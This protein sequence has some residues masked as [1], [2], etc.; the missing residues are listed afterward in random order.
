MHSIL[1][2]LM[3]GAALYAERAAATQFDCAQIESRWRSATAGTSFDEWTSI[4]YDAHYESNCGNRIVG[5]IGRDIIERELPAIRSAYRASVDEGSLRALR[6]RLDA[7]LEY[8]SH[9]EISFLLGETARK[10]RDAT[11]ALTAYRE[12]LGLVDNEELTPTPPHRDDIALLRDRLDETAIVVAQLSPASMKLPVNRTGQLI[13]Q[14]SFATRGYKRKKAL[15]PILFVFAKDV[16]TDA[17][18]TIFA[19]VLETLT[20]QGSP[21]ITVVGHTD[22]IGSRESNMQL[23][24]ERAAAVKRALLAESYA[25]RVT[26]RGMGEEQPFKF[27]DPG[28]YS[29]KTR[30]Q[31]HRR[32]EFILGGN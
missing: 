29:E 3:L 10:Q 8:G 11:G 24:L 19:D 7:L 16:L 21:D 4:Y 22:P 23:S 25:G 12:A 18:R 15:A 5:G 27:D 6:G 14:Y 20:K 1:V 13:S 26:T 32:V 30:N 17:G 2:V 28:L 9:W 31:S